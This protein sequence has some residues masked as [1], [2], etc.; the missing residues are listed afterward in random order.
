MRL[1]N[2][3]A[4][5][6]GAEGVCAEDCAEPKLP[7][8][9]SLQHYDICLDNKHTYSVVVIVVNEERKVIE[10]IHPL[11]RDVAGDEYI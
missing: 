10:N 8:Q 1:Y 5:I 11:Q 3:A 9:L 7:C 4:K 2:S 6:F